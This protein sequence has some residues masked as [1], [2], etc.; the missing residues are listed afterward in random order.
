V[1]LANVDQLGALGER[2]VQLLNIDLYDCHTST[3]P[4][5]V[6]SSVDIDQLLRL[7]SD[8]DHS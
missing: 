8:I 2:G 3:L 4:G 5:Q 1:L 6:G 7:D